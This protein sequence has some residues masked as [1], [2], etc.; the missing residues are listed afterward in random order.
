[1]QGE[2]FKRSLTNNSYYNTVNYT[3]DE[4]HQREERAHSQDEMVIEFFTKRPPFEFT[5]SEVSKGLEG[6]NIIDK[7]VRRS[8]STLS[9]KN[10]LIKLDKKKLGPLGSYEHFYKLISKIS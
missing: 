3:G 6:C 2:L 10:I 7:S 1:M 9:K 8:L 4:L 5:A